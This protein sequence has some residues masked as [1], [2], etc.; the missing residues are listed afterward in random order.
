MVLV[1]LVIALAVWLSLNLAVAVWLYAQSY[2]AQ[3]R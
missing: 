3:P 1:C 2:R